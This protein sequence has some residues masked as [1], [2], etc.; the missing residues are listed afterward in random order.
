[1]ILETSRL[2]LRTPALDDA[3]EIARVINDQRITRTLVVVPYPYSVDDAITWI[4]SLS[5]PEKKAN[6]QFTVFLKETNEVAG[7]VGLVVNE[8]GRRG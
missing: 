8:E 4:S 3:A 1:M 2:I 6:A 7:G 5:A